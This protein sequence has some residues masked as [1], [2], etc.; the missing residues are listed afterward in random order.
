MPPHHAA[1]QDETQERV[2][3]GENL[4]GI[5]GEVVKFPVKGS[6]AVTL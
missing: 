4:L 3:Q 5:L 1:G 6:Q 2:A